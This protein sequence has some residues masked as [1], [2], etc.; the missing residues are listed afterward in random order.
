MRCRCE[1]FRRWIADDHFIKWRR[2]VLNGHSS[3]DIGAFVTK[4]Q[5]ALVEL[6]TRGRT[7]TSASLAEVV[8][9]KYSKC[10]R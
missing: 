10:E 8:G 1:I 4:E 3:E 7:T 2:A 6:S 9:C 5:C